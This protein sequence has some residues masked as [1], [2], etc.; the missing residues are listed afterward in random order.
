MVTSL[1]QLIDLIQSG[2]VPAWLREYVLAHKDDIAQ[3]LRERGAFTIPGPNG[4]QINIR[5][6]KTSATAAA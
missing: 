4:E 3:T 6:E 2:A 1:S 5:T